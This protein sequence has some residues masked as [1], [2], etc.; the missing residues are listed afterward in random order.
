MRRC[1]LSSTVERRNRKE[2]ASLKGAAVGFMAAFPVSFLI[3]ALTGNVTAAQCGGFAAGLIVLPLHLKSQ[4]ND[5]K[6]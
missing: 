5:V 4:F 1:A 3:A 2:K 6:N